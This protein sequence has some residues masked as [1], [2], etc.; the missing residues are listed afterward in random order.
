MSDRCTEHMTHTFIVGFGAGFCALFAV[1]GGKGFRKRGGT[2]YEVFRRNL[3]RSLITGIFIGIFFGL[4][5]GM[6]CDDVEMMEIPKEKN[7]WKMHQGRWKELE[8]AHSEPR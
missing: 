8:T 2:V 4:F 1:R 3:K 5:A 7:F 6:R